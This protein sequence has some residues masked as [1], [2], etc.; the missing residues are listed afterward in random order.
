M[1]EF[2]KKWLAGVGAAAV[3]TA[4]AVIAIGKMERKSA[5]APSSH[6]AASKPAAQSPT[7][8][9]PVQPQAT[10]SAVTPP[11]EPSKPKIPA[12]SEEVNLAASQNAAQKITKPHV[13]AA[14]K[15][16]SSAAPKASSQASNAPTSAPANAASQPQVAQT[17]APA[18]PPDVA[19]PAPQSM[20][21]EAQPAT[22]QV[23]QPEGMTITGN[24]TV[25]G[26]FSKIS[27]I[28]YPNDQVLTPEQNGALATA[29]GNAI[30]LGANTQFKPD[31]TN[32]FQLDSGASNVSTKTG[33]TA[34]V[35]GDWRV[36][37]VHP[38][39]STQYEVNYEGD[40]VYVYARV[41]DVDVISDPCH[42]SIRVEQGKAIRI[43]NFKGCGVGWLDGSGRTWPYKVAWGSAAAGG[44]GVIIWLATQQRQNLSPP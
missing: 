10:A 4:I 36:E 42:R 17:N 34:K 15:T 14:S 40:A 39:A 20:Q 9:A 33:M 37:P 2:A 41:N 29:K 23:V 26:E 5:P 22:M 44:T 12:Q 32:S 11:S 21:P 8:P 18:A 3:V 16:G 24:V 28:V 43:P 30:A 1:G 38:D 35:K 27:R 25:G 7:A 13:R 6:I 31:T 19:T